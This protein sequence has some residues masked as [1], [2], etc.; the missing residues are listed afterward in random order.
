MK[1]SHEKSKG[2]PVKGTKNIQAVRQ[3]DENV[4]PDNRPQQPEGKHPHQKL[5]GEK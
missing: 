1:Q 5:A 2:Q 4:K 3:N